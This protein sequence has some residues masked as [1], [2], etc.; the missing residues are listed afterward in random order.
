MTS[1]SGS[2]ELMLV[3]LIVFSVSG[4]GYMSGFVSRP[5]HEILA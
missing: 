1:A 2:G 4:M 3:K 5:L